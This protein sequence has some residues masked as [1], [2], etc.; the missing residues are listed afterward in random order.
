KPEMARQQ[1]YNFTVWVADER[2]PEVAARA[3]Q[4]ALTVT[5][6]FTAAISGNTKLEAGQG[7]TLEVSGA[8]AGSTYQWLV[9]KEVVAVREINRL[10][11]LPQQTTTYRLSVTSPAGC[12]FSDSVR[13]EVAEK[14]VYAGDLKA[15][16]NIFTPNGDGINDF[17][18]IVL[19][20]EGAI[21]LEI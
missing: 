21:D 7:T 14:Q 13:V 1:P 17:F 16:P 10:I 15:I 12:T 20:E 19:P 18:E 3:Y 8:P 9:G 2:C 5:P 11:I 4:Y 6:A